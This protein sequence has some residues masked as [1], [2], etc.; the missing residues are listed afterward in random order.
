MVGCYL[1]PPQEL[2]Q[3]ESVA[4]NWACGLLSALDPSMLFYEWLLPI[5]FPQQTA[6]ASGKAAHQSLLLEVLHFLQ[7]FQKCYILHHEDR[8]LM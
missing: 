8:R 5:P 6:T 7:T 4:F 1:E 3:T 2:Q